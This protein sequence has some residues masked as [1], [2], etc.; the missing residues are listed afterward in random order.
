MKRL[1]L[2]LFTNIL[3]MCKS[4]HWATYSHSKHIA[5][6]QAYDSFNETFDKF[7]ETALGIYG[8]ES[9]VTTP[10]S[11]KLVSDED[12]VNY[13]E[14]E[15]VTFN[16]AIIPIVNEY[17]QLSSLF[18]EIKAAENQLMYRLKSAN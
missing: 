12:I 5:L 15:L 8:R 6:D 13:V 16:N 2:S 18:D 10:L 4:L 7:I 14:S 11:V 3:A 1:N 9:A 17:T